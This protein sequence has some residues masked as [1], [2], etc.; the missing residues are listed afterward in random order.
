MY[1]CV[2]AHFA[3]GKIGRRTEALV[4]AD[5]L[6][7]VEFLSRQDRNNT[8]TPAGRTNLLTAASSMEPHKE[9]EANYLIT[10]VCLCSQVGADSH[11]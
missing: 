2:C 3:G 1:V 5:T 4:S 9:E 11:S 7:V 10:V 8:R 6:I